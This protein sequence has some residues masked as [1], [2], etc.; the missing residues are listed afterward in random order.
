MK[1]F[2]VKEMYLTLQGEGFHSGRRAVFVRFSGCNLWSGK[3]SD[4]ETALC[5]FCDTDFVGTDGVNGG[6]YD[7]VELVRKIEWLWGNHETRKFVVF[8][9]GEP[10]L[11][12]TAQL[13]S[14]LKNREYFTAVETNGTL[15]MVVDVDWI[16]VSPKT[17]HLAQSFGSEIKLVYP[18]EG[19]EPDYFLT[20]HFRHYYL[21]PKED[22]NAKSN[23]RKTVSYCLSNPQWQ[24]SLQTHK[25]VNIP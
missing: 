8:T 23:L 6:K 20:N 4:R 14:E 15:P 22:A 1:K 3:E 16:T 19:I 25:L 9:G 21:Q 12:L 7:Y 24:L 10:L 13:I 11:Q 17:K 2:K 18:Q 5:N